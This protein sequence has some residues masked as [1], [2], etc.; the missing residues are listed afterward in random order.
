MSA[1][2]VCKLAVSVAVPALLASA[3]LVP[4]GAS[5]AA[6]TKA[7]DGVRLL[8][9]P[10]VVLGIGSVV[11]E[12]TGPVDDLVQ[13]LPVDLPRS[14]RAAARGASSECKNAGIAGGELKAR[15]AAKAVRCVINAERAAHGLKALDA[16]GD[17]KQAAK[18]HTTRMVN[19]GLFFARLPGRTRSRLE[20]HLDRLSAVHVHLERRREHRLGSGRQRKPGVDRRRVDGVAP[21]P[22]DDPDA[23]HDGGRRRRP[24]RQARRGQGRRGDVHRRLRLPQVIDALS[25]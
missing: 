8:S 10:Y 18:R 16:Q 5:A 12:V 14:Q 23:E 11:L 21:A 13:C 7:C 1:R 24:P 22:G 25:A 19:D 9:A 15:R 20:G 6:S 2:S 17:L 4:Q 3:L